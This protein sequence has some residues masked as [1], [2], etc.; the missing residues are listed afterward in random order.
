MKKL[1]ITIMSVLMLL[2]LASPTMAAVNFSVNGDNLQSAVVPQNVSG[3]T[4]IPLSM[5]EKILGVDVSVSGTMITVKNNNDV[6][7]MTVGIKNAVLNGKNISLTQAPTIVDGKILVP[8]RSILQTL[9]AQINWLANTQTIN[10]DYNEKQGGLSAEDILIKTNEAMAQLNIYKMKVNMNQHMTMTMGGETQNVDSKVLMDMAAQNKPLVI[11]ADCTMDVSG[12][13]EQTK[14]KMQLLCNETGM[15]MNTN[16]EGWIKMNTPG[17]DLSNMMEQMGAQN[18]L[19]CLQ[20]MKDA[21]VVLSLGNEVEKNSHKY[22][23]VN[24]VMNKEAVARLLNDSLKNTGLGSSGNADVDTMVQNMLDSLQAELA[25]TIL[26]DQGTCLPSSIKM[27]CSVQMTMKVP[28]VGSMKMTISEP[29]TYEFYG[30]GEPI[31]VPDVSGAK[32]M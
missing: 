30:F 17:A 12:L 26:V 22:W 11:T 27:D 2:L 4:M 23:S 31:T 1:S 24:V 15:Y 5:L 10:V 18:P 21:G 8:A 29:G 13:G 7:Q 19:G 6:L 28:G 9:G 16:N 20:Q 32:S 3:T 25:Y 14:I